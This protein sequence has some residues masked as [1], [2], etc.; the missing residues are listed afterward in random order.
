MARTWLMA[1]VVFCFGL[2]AGGWPAKSHGRPWDPSRP[3]I[4]GLR[5]TDGDQDLGVVWQT[6][7]LQVTFHLVNESSHET[8]RADPIRG[9]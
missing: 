4:P 8:F 9:G 6:D 1:V 2:A 3:L 5:C 7:A